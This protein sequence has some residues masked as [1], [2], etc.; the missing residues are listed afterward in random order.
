MG[1]FV[2][3]CVL[4]ELLMLC[5]VQMLQSELLDCPDMVV[6][7]CTCQC[8]QQLLTVSLFHPVIN[9]SVMLSSSIDKLFVS[10]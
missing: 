4:C 7:Y 2:T 10:K 3:G 6:S 9:C 1:Y 8:L 5:C